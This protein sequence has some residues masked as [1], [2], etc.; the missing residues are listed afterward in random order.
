M[1]AFG[2]AKTIRNYNSSRFGKYVRIWFEEKTKKIKEADIINY[3]LEKSR[4]SMQS[5]GERNYHIFYHFLRGAS[6]DLLNQYKLTKDL[7]YYDYLNKSGCYDADNIDDVEL[8]KGVCECFE[9]MKFNSEEVSAIWSVLAAILK[10]GNLEFDDT[11]KTDT[12]PCKIV[13]EALFDEISDLLQIEMEILRSALIIKTRIT[14]KEKFLCPLDKNECISVRDSFSKCLYDKVFN[15]II[16]RLNISIKNRENNN[17]NK[18]MSI[19]LLDIFGFED[20]K[21]N[22]LEQFCINFTNEKLQQLYINYIFKSEHREFVEEG[23]ESFIGLI[24]F[25][26]NQAIIDLF[27][28]PPYGIF[29]LLDEATTLKSSEDKRL[30]ETIVKT[31]KDNPC[32]KAPKSV[33]EIFIVV[34]SAKNVEYNITGFRRKNKDEINQEIEDAVT[35]SKNPNIYNIYVG[36]CV[37]DKYKENM[38][39]SKD[40]SPNPFRIKKG[41]K[42]MGG[43]DK[44]LGTKFRTQMKQLME[45]LSSCD[46]HFIRCLKPNEM[47]KSDNFVPITVLSQIRYLGLLDS[48]KVRKNTYPAR[49]EFYDFYK[50]Y[51]EI[52]KSKGCKDYSKEIK[53]KEYRHLCEEIVKIALE[54]KITSSEVLYG[55]TKIYL[56][57][58]IEDRIDRIFLKMWKS[59]QE[60]AKKIWKQYKIFKLRRG[61]LKKLEVIYKRMKNF[62]RF[63]AICKG[64]IQRKR[65]LRKKKTV[66]MMVKIKKKMDLKVCKENFR[67]LHKICHEMKKWQSKKKASGRIY[68]LREKIMGK[69]TKQF[70][71]SFK[72]QCEI[73]KQ[74]ILE[75][76]RKEEEQKQL[77]LQKQKKDEEEKIKREEEILIKKQKDEEKR[78]ILE[79]QKKEEEIL[80]QTQK[81]EENR[82]LLQ[83]KKKEKDE[84]NRVLLEKQKKEEEIIEQKR[85]DEEKRLLLEKQKEQELQ[86]KKQDDE[87]LRKIQEEILEKKNEENKIILENKRKLDENMQKQK[88]QEEEIRTS[89]KKPKDTNDAQSKLAEELRLSMEKKQKTTEHSNKIIEEKQREDKQKLQNQKEEEDKLNDED[90]KLRTCS[91]SLP[92]NEKFQPACKNQNPIVTNQ[93][94]FQDRIK[95]FNQPKNIKESPVKCEYLYILIL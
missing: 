21:I 58:D 76:K 25:Q 49:K 60:K 22:S 44:F 5:I 10:L 1:E 57:G 54:D 27:D 71:E 52:L 56:K 32:F 7:K 51:Q 45:E 43:V 80:K 61:I 37:T 36:E 9:E 73:K 81:D 14:D 84:E 83:K 82:L 85:K 93:V 2:N 95:L 19:G 38:E 6:Q 64:K 75:R 4:V 3:L 46:A 90:F 69:L 18:I 50:K 72:K 87:N 16:H 65:F 20:F 66:E 24:T 34:H 53:G 94:S 47:K 8:F 11:K 62:K 63:Q 79:K 26:D 55:K 39:E 17:D 41:T 40:M 13:N 12:N 78:I 89:V 59:K 15:W 42:S 33:F 92:E 67:K 35:H 68:N 77:L 91:E 48:I 86:R 74:C 28:K 30:L 88:D 70:Y 29:L 31:H 23:L